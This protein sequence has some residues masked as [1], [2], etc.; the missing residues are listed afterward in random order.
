MAVQRTQFP[1]TGAYAF[2]DYRSQ[3]QT[4]SQ[5]IIDIA[6]PSRGSLNL[7]NL[8]VALSQC[9]EREHIQLLRGFKPDMLLNES[10]LEDER[11]ECMDK[12]TTVWWER[13]KCREERQA[14]MIGTD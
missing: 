5:A 3:G 2:T 13:V 7:F 10:L 9:P 4:I 11:L 12:H 1:I 8:Y 14:T 6:P